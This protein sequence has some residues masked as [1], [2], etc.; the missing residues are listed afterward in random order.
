MT[1]VTGCCTYSMVAGVD[2]SEFSVVLDLAKKPP[3]SCSEKSK[4]EKKP[5]FIL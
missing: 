2:V 4:E 5:Q 3:M 1:L